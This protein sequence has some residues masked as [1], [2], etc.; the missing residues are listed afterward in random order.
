MSR[1]EHANARVAALEQL[2]AASERENGALR[3]EAATRGAE[4]HAEVA[5]QRAHAEGSRLTIKQK[6]AAERAVA[7]GVDI[8]ALLAGAGSPHISSPS[9]TFAHLLSHEGA[10]LFS[11]QPTA[12][13]RRR[14][15]P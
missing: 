8:E 14:Q 11:S 7:S 5:R 10:P 12:L 3:R 6:E 4:V 1:A 9:M 13:W 15:R 2:L